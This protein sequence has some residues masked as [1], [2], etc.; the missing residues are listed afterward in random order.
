[1]PHVTAAAQQRDTQ[2]WKMRITEAKQKQTNCNEK[3]RPNAISL[4]FFF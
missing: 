1:M 2:R 4:C 3:K